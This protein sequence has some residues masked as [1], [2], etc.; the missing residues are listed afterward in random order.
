MSF[1]Q[2]QMSLIQKIADD[3]SLRGLTKTAMFL[4]DK[5]SI[6]DRDYA[7]TKTSEKSISNKYKLAK[8]YF[9]NQEYER[10][11]HLLENEKSQKKG[12]TAFP[13]AMFLS[14]FSR[15]KS[16]QKKQRE[17]S[18][19]SSEE[20]GPT[21]TLKPKIENEITHKYSNLRRDVAK[22]LDN[23][24]QISSNETHQEESYLWYLNGVLHQILNNRKDATKSL[25]MS[26]K[27][28]PH[29][30]ASWYE[31]SKVLPLSEPNT[32]KKVL[33]AV[34]PTQNF[35]KSF[36]VAKFLCT[37]KCYETMVDQELIYLKD[38]CSLETSG[39]YLAAEAEFLHT[40]QNYTLCIEKFT[41]MRN[42]DPYRF[43]DCDTYSNVLFTSSKRVELASLAHELNEA[44][45]FRSEVCIVLGNYY[46][47]YLKYSPESVT[48]GTLAKVTFYSCEFSWIHQN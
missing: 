17:S 34:C 23:Y 10:C 1:N 19:S 39:D 38:G 44:D 9:D 33:S 11:R 25:M 14:L 43:E 35:C 32:V 41:E 4:Y 40:V 42:R 31:L 22:E 30:W 29:L 21:I 15:F 48:W 18:L 24:K 3:A 28:N 46:D 36:F 12:S 16:I 27:F 37:K 13:E 26:I 20:I 8:C 47:Q 7:I 6:S 2:V 5:I 45:P